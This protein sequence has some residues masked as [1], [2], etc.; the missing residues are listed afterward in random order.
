MGLSDAK[1][2]LGAIHAEPFSAAEIDAHPDCGRIWATIEAVKR[3]LTEDLG[4]DAF[5]WGDE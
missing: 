1:I 5:F 3:E 4:Q 2:P